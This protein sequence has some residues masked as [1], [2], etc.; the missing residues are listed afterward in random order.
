MS[1]NE[2]ATRLYDVQPAHVVKWLV[3]E[4]TKV[5]EDQQIA[6]I[7]GPAQYSKSLL[8]RQ[9]LKAPVNGTL[10]NLTPVQPPPPPQQQQQQQQSMLSQK[11]DL[12]FPSTL[13]ST[14]P[15]AQILYCTHSVVYSGLCTLCAVNVL[16]L[17]PRSRQLWEMCHN[18]S[19]VASSATTKE[20]A[21]GNEHFGKGGGHK[22][23]REDVFG[24]QKE[25]V[26]TG[27]GNGVSI[28]RG[29]TQIRVQH[30]FELSVSSALATTADSEILSR[31]RSRRKLCLVLD[32]DHTLIHCVSDDKA[33][34]FVASVTNG[35]SSSSESQATRGDDTHVTQESSLSSSSS[36][37][38]PSMVCS[39]DVF[40][41]N[42]GTVIYAI[43][44][45]PFLS[46]FLESAS[47]F[48][49]LQVDTAGTRTYAQMVLSHI[50]P[51][52]RLFGD[53]I[54]SRC[55]SRLRHKQVAW[56]HRAVKDDSMV[57]IVDDTTE[58]WRGAKNLL[59]IEP[60][61]FW[62][63]GVSQVELN[64]VSGRSMVDTSYGV[65]S[66]A[67][68]APVASS[69]VNEELQ[70]GS[71]TIVVNAPPPPIFEEE[72]H[73]YLRDI[74]SFLKDIHKEYYKEYDLYQSFVRSSNTSSS[75]TSSSSSNVLM[76]TIKT[77]STSE[78]TIEG[79]EGGVK[80]QTESSSKEVSSLVS[81][82]RV[83]SL[84]V[85]IHQQLR[86]ILS[87]VCIVF[88]G[89][90]S[91]SSYPEDT[92]LWNR[93]LAFGA[94]IAESPD[95]TRSLTKVYTQEEL[96]EA[97]SKNE[98]E[99]QHSAHNSSAAY[100]ALQS[101]NKK[102]VTHL[103]YRTAGTAKFESAS[104]DP[105]IRLVPL[106]W[107]EQSIL[108]Y[109][110]LPEDDFVST[111]SASYSA[112]QSL[113]DRNQAAV[114]VND[115]IENKR[116]ILAE[117]VARKRTSDAQKDDDDEDDEEEDVDDEKEGEEGEDRVDKNHRGEKHPN[118][119]GGH[120]LTRDTHHDYAEDVGVDGEVDEEDFG[121]EEDVDFGAELEAYEG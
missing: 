58:V 29:M 91:L 25:G 51:D 83:P 35:T 71:T 66:N 93:A 121:H 41:W 81:I 5:K 23:R 98:S 59:T 119:L 26:V 80:L 12:S 76:T 107:L 90:F 87:N 46:E 65:G 50:D 103:V 9:I 97:V 13:S 39:S 104:K 67:L 18:E 55:D 6:E 100:S 72:G 77:E 117:A 34:A 1:S 49:E 101:F 85:I 22:R 48:F 94:T 84:P 24:I 44:K 40:S 33:A 64:N 112:K 21:K 111:S 43:K 95:S 8:V 116:L 60:Y 74:L 114:R 62:K 27:G 19:S 2:S 75:S 86:R 42:D 88:S 28:P 109:R 70:T 63:S 78:S 36:P 102:I 17:P 69:S 105:A 14:R 30:G 31:L 4:G 45:R 106:A 120:A 11:Q 57:V 73:P 15:S 37:T 68:E 3:S 96:D 110:R 108:Q 38:P 79:R 92:N 99:E 20:D 53:R 47:D 52:K 82:P 115:L 118:T 89:V 7:Y 16:A 56:L 113:F 54:V 10:C 32:I 61:M